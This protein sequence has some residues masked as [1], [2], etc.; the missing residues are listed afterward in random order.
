[1]PGKSERQ[2]KRV[3]SSIMITERLSVKVL[4]KAVDLIVVE[5]NRENKSKILVAVVYLHCAN[6]TERNVQMI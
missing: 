2:G 6:T 4:L 1:V 5:V 3:D